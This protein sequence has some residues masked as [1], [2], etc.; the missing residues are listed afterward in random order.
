SP[1]FAASYRKEYH[2]I[3][4]FSPLPRARDRFRTAVSAW[5]ITRARDLPQLRR[6]ISV[7]CAHDAFDVDIPF[8][9]A[10]GRGVVPALAAGCVR[11]AARPAGATAFA[12]ADTRR[13]RAPHAHRRG[14]SHGLGHRHPDGIRH[15]RHRSG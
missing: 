15:A 7:S 12:G 11:D 10:H 5:R 6:T 3:G 4:S 9:P 8:P 13:D 1:T 2:T 14:G